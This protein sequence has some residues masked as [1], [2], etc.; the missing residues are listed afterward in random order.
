M[1]V[2]QR[3]VTMPKSD[4]E[5]RAFAAYFRSGGTEQ[6]SES[7]SGV[8]EHAGKMYVVLRNA[9]GLLACYRVRNDGKLKLL[10]RLPSMI[11]EENQR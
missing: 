8:E 4:L 5:R 7:G 1:N 11:S 6:P 2:E 9:S 10:R 3:I